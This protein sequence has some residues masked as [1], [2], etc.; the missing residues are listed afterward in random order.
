MNSV[1]SSI[2]SEQISDKLTSGKGNFRTQN[3]ENDVVCEKI[4]NI[5]PQPESNVDEKGNGRVA[6]EG[7][8]RFFVD[9]LSQICSFNGFAIAKDA[10]IEKI[11]CLPIVIRK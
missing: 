5:T 6:F 8:G 2:F 7:K 9:G 1:H 4:E 11:E 10:R 3:G